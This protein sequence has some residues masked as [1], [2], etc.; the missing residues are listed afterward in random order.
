MEKD[1]INIEW[2]EL[3]EKLV[4]NDILRSEYGKNSEQGNRKIHQYKPHD[5]LNTTLDRLNPGFSDSFFTKSLESELEKILDAN[6]FA[7]LNKEQREN[8]QNQ[9]DRLNMDE[10]EWKRRISG[11]HSDH[12]V[13]IEFFDESFKTFSPMLAKFLSPKQED[14]KMTQRAD[15]L[16]FPYKFKAFSGGILHILS[17]H[18]LHLLKDVNSTLSEEDFGK[19]IKFHLSKKAIFVDLVK[20]IMKNARDNA[21]NHESSNP[22]V[23]LEET[24]FVANKTDVF[25]EFRRVFA[26]NLVTSI[27]CYYNEEKNPNSID[28]ALVSDKIRNFIYRRTYVYDREDHIWWVN[29]LTSSVQTIMDFLEQSKF[30]LGLAK[31]KLSSG[32]TEHIIYALPAKMEDVLITFTAFPR[33]IPPKNV[34]P[35]MIEDKLKQSL[36]GDN[37]VSKSNSFTKVLNIAQSKAFAVN[38]KVIRLFDTLMDPTQNTVAHDISLLKTIENPFLTTYQLKIMKDQV[39]DAKDIAKIGAFEKFIADILHTSFVG[40]GI[41]N[42]SFTSLLLLAGVSPLEIKMMKEGEIAQYRLTAETH[43]RKTAETHLVLGKL[44]SGVPI[45]MTNTYC[46]RLRLYPE[47]PF[48]S[49]TSG[50]FKHLLC[51]YSPTKITLKGMTSLLKC[52]YIAAKQFEEKFEKFCADTVISKK[53]GM[54]I[55]KKFFDENTIDFTILKDNFI[56]VSVLYLE[57]LT[58]LKTGKTQIMVEID[59]KASGMVFLGLAFRNRKLASYSNV[60]SKVKQCPYTYCMNKF[61]KFYYT[62]MENRDSQAFDFL[63]KNKKLHKYASMCYTYSQK[64]IGRKE[65]FVERWYTEIGVLSESAKAVLT[66]FAF[67][68]DSFIEYVYPGITEQIKNLLELVKFVVNETGETCINNL[69]GEKLRWRRFKHKSITRKGFN[70]I[71]KKQLSYRVETLIT[72]NGKEMLDVTDHKRKFL[73]YL[74]HSIDAAVMHYFI[75][76]MHEKYNYTINHLHDCVLVH[77]N[78]VDHFYEIVRRLYTSDKLYNIIETSV[79]G[80]AE[81][82]LSKE[83]THVVQK[84]R[85]TFLKLSDDFRN[86]LKDHVP[87]NIYRPES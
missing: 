45:Y 29:D 70:P 37:R 24:P 66:E 76:E 28:V 59:Q 85:E 18:G 43:K 82:S 79:F 34:T 19:I 9:L 73:A 39:N 71:T 77:P 56:Y 5:M 1:T 25:Y 51:E 40:K 38:N 57:I 4:K 83:S 32:K 12:K 21:F 75:L 81:H 61:E 68:Y 48:M 67:K 72:A 2:R 53:T 13:I 60:I 17:C 22:T 55:L 65:D 64:G 63:K 36:F 16:F 6:Q 14:L 35:E 11:Y 49:R 41:T 84:A 8:I 69:N 20:V 10:Y 62:T 80:P 30:F 74:I 46:V 23:F 58:A 54:R 7:K 47:Q 52:F 87:E 27:L 44:F 86:E 3:L 78:H 33:I 26:L 15:R 42:I 50:V 31:E